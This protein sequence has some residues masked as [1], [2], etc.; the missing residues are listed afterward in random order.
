MKSFWMF[1][2]IFGLALPAVRLVNNTIRMDQ[3]QFSQFEFY[4]IAKPT[5]LLF[6]VV[7]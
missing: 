1:I 5:V 6:T 3:S 7:M 4:L 2:F